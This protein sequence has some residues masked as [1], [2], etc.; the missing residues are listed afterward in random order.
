MGWYD[1]QMS[2]GP[3]APSRLN[4]CRDGQFQKVSDGGRQYVLI[5]FVM[6]LVLLESAERPGNIGGYGRLLSYD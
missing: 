6:F 1:G 5:A 2:K 4:S 3:F